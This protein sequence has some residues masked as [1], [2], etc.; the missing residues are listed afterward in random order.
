MILLLGFAFVSGLFTILAPCIWPVLPIVLSSSIAGRSVG[1]QKPLGITLGVMLSFSIFTLFLSYLVNI[2][3][4]DSNVLRLIAVVVIAF[5]GLTMIVPILAAKLEAAV[6]RISGLFGTTT[7]TNTGF[8]GGFFTGLSLGIV[9]SPCAGPILATIATLAATG[10][11]TLSIIFVTIAYVIGIGIPL[12]LFAYGGQ[13]IILRAK[14]INKYTGRMQQIFGVIM[15]LT[16]LA[17]YTHY[18]T[19]LEAQL[20]NLFPQFSSSLNSFESNPAIKQQLDTLRGTTTVGT[21][22][23][24]S[25]YGPAPEFTG[26]TK[27]LNLPD[28]KQTLSIHDLKG[29]VVLVDFWTY[30]CINCIRTLPH[31][32]SWYE[33]YKNQGFVVVGVHTPEFQFEHETTNVMQAI[34]MY[35]IHYPV[36]QDNDYATWNAYS[37][38]YWPAE[39]LIDAKGNIRHVHFG[40]GE[41]DT[42]EQVIQQLLQEA[43]KKVTTKINSMP[44]Q[45]PTQ[46]ISPETY[47]GSKRMEFYDPSGSLGNGVQSFTLTENPNLNSFSYGG[48][49]NITEETAIAQDNATLAYHFIAS[50]VYIILRPPNTETSGK[51]KILLDGKPIDPSVAGKDVVNGEVT[52]NTDR[53]YNIVDL[54]NATQNHVLKIEFE[55]P[56][57][58]AYTFTFG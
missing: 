15:L 3:H 50:K 17:I 23:L 48:T 2:F 11:V 55:T 4:F 45:T 57:T 42:T 41:Y 14:G 39:Y 30:T 20:L 35:N 22:S 8:I 19:Y 37:N 28:G 13:Q 7:N 1:H 6:S 40:E 46:N 10:K 33:K 16:A 47:L 27:W 36:A 53:L 51:V 56:E 31:V 32:T 58:Q 21:S 52:V 25:N 54:H 49:W 43:G 34:Q 12:F 26:I 5:L 24:L 9:W 38:Q 18:D 29:K 44:D